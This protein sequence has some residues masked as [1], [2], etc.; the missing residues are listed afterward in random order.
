VAEIC[1]YIYI[2]N[3]RQDL[4]Y[5]PKRGI[6]F[7]SRWDMTVSHISLVRLYRET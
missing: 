4:G 3:F 1:E 6:F 5:V 2:S 7:L